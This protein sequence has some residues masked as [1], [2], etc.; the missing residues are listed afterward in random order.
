MRVGVVCILLAASAAGLFISSPSPARAQE[1][2]F[3]ASADWLN[4]KARRRGMDFVIVDPNTNSSVQGNQINLNYDRNSG[5]RVVFG[6]R[7]DSCWELAAEYQHFDTNDQLLVNQPAGGSLWGTRLHPDSVVGDRYATSAEGRATLNY[8]VI[9]FVISRQFAMDCSR[10]VN[11]TLFGGFRYAMVDQTLNINYIDSVNSRSAVIN[12]EIKLDGYGIRA[13]GRL[14]W[15]IFGGLSVFGQGAVSVLA[16][17][18]NAHYTETDHNGEST[19]DLVNVTE[20]YYQ[21]VPVVE[22]ALGVAFRRGYW[23]VA[24]GY[25]MALWG[26]VGERRD[27]VDDIDEQKFASPSNDLLLDGFFLRLAYNR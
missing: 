2:G 11:F 7:L 4:W 27:F 20:T 17:R 16:A 9:D 21:A 6:Y 25:E 1:S 22:T 5:A 14:E 8:D 23:E 19:N 15:N 10:R 26:N 3:Y 12:D 24:G 13:G 18:A